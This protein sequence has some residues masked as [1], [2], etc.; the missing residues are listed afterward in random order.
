MTEH[1]PRPDNQILSA[2]PQS[3]FQ[4]LAPY[5]KTIAVASGDILYEPY[6]PIREVYFPDGAMISLVSIMEDGSMTEVGLVGK[7]GMAGLPV[8]LGGKTTTSQGII[9]ISG[10]VVR[11]DANILKQEF[12]QG[13]ELQRLLLLYTQAL[14]TQISQTAVCNCKHV[15]EQRLARWLLTVCDCIQQE[16]FHLTQE[17]ISIMLGVRRSS[18]TVAAGIL[19]QGGAIRYR[20]GKIT[21]LNRDALIKTACECYGLVQTE[22]QRLLGD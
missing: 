4:R 2:L 20:R 19:Q 6:E 15:I 1:H 10:T 3:E 17:F 16:E 13:G 11:L 8:V 12:Q 18:V 14:M 21:I 22:Y 9:Q 7:E 5:L